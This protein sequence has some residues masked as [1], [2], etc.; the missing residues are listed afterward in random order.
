MNITLENVIFFI[1]F[2]AFNLLIFLLN[3]T[4]KELQN[5]IQEN[6]K[7]VSSIILKQAIMNE[8][9]T[10]IEKEIQELKLNYTNKKRSY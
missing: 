10:L 5:R 4:F 2:L 7:N 1:A 6:T 3:K 9:L 8:K